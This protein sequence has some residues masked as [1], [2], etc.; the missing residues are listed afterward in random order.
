MDMA[1][2]PWLGFVDAIKMAVSLVTAA[3]VWMNRIFRRV[4]FSMMGQTL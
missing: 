2:A 3:R 4:L 1:L